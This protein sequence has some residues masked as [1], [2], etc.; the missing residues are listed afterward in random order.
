[1][2]KAVFNVFL[3]NITEMTDNFH[4]IYSHHGASTRQKKDCFSNHET[5][6]RVKKIRI[7]LENV[8]LSRKEERMDEMLKKL[9]NV[10]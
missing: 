1:M 5:L 8:Y 10:T 9:N 6:T 4:V 3:S 7:G 2:L